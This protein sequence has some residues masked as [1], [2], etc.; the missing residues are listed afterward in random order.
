MSNTIAASAVFRAAAA[1]TVLDNISAR[2][3]DMYVSE[4]ASR[5]CKIE[6]TLLPN[7][8][9]C[10]RR[11]LRSG[12]LTC[13]SP[14]SSTLSSKWLTIRTRCSV[15]GRMAIDPARLRVDAVSSSSWG[16]TSIIRSK[17]EAASENCSWVGTVYR[18]NQ[19]RLACSSLLEPPDQVEVAC[20]SPA[21]DCPGLLSDSDGGTVG[22]LSSTG[23]ADCVP[24]STAAG[25]APCKYSGFAELSS[26][27][28]SGCF[29]EAQQTTLLTEQ[30]VSQQIGPARTS[31]MTTNSF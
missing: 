27:V 24:S 15:A 8:S 28:C 18:C 9:A 21:I 5:S 14:A 29:S 26:G 2:S 30:C 20:S 19:A 4:I 10:T 11:S 22:W 12:L 23:S 31:W 17:H 16:N 7:A 13:I 1:L 3:F 25:S 6:F